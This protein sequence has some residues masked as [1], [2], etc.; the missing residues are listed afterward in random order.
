MN[1]LE[2]LRRFTIIVADTG[3]INSIHHYAPQDITTNPS[4]ILKVVKLPI[5][6][7]LLLNSIE[8]ARK[9]GG[10]LKEKIINASDKLIVNIGVEILKSIP[11][12]VSTEID[13]RL[14]F[15]KNMCIDKARRLINLYQEQGVDKCRILIKLSSTWE[16]IKAAEILEKEN[17]NCN[18]TLLFSFVQAR[19]CAE[20]NVHLISPFVGR[21]YDWYNKRKLIEPYSVEK[22]PGVQLVKKIFYYYKKH[23]YKTIIMGASFRKIE[24]ILALSGCDYLTIS[25]DFLEQLSK[26][27]QNVICQLFSPNENTCPLPIP[28]SEPEFRWNHNQ[29]AM[30]VEK[31]SEGIRQFSIDQQHIE[32]LLMKYL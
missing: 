12:R 17:I 11:G 18:L 8:Y 20:S 25:P 27:K 28:F 4:L 22:D 29:D 6:Q 10:T 19:A 16:G 3:N 30:A 9:K 21:V 23:H 2:S 5:Y 7:S 15:N 14:S 1:Q 24:Q 26:N 31:L 32:T 13:A